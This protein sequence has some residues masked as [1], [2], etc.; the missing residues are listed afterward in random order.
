MKFGKRAVRS[1][2]AAAMTVAMLLSLVP[3]TFAAEAEKKATITVLQTSDLHGMVNPFDY[4]ANKEA[5]TSMAHI[6]TIVAEQR[7]LDP[8]LLLIDT[9]DTLQ[10]N[11]IQEF[12]KD[13]PN[14]M[15]DAMN[16]LKYDVWTLG[17]HEFNFE[18]DV[19]KKS[20]SEFKG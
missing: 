11:Y 8:S 17:N 12:R 7:K 3:A 1:L 9:G 14:P 6:A 5:K 20:I 13:V 19:L 10:A 16:Y 18:F 4:A 2:V 15:I